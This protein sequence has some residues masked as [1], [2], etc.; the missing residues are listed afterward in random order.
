M[1]PDDVKSVQFFDE[2]LHALE[3]VAYRYKELGSKTERKIRKF[4]PYILTVSHDPAFR[5]V[6]I[7]YTEN[8]NSYSGLDNTHFLSVCGV[9][10]VPDPE[11][12]VNMSYVTSFCRILNNVYNINDQNEFMNKYMDFFMTT[13][14]WILHSLHIEKFFDT[15]NDPLN[16]TWEE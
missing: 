13:Q 3:L 16:K 4:V 6:V 2:M 14:L 1:K 7:A 15:L 5:D 9:L 11:D 10:R 12:P 8:N